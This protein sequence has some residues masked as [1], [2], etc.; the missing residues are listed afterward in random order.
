[1]NLQ[2]LVAYIKEQKIQGVPDI[3]I[4]QTLVNAG[5]SDVLI[6]QG[7]AAY[8]KSLQPKAAPLKKKRITLSRT[9][10]KVIVWVLGVVLLLVL[11]VVGV[12]LAHRNNIVDVSRLGLSATPQKNLALMLAQLERGLAQPAFDLKIRIEAS[13]WPI[14]PGYAH[15]VATPIN[16]LAADME[17]TVPGKNKSGGGFFTLLLVAEPGTRAETR[18]LESEMRY[19]AEH[20]T[21]YVRIGES[22]LLN[23]FGFDDFGRVWME[24]DN[25]A[26][27]RTGEQFFGDE[28]GVM[29]AVPTPEAV[30]VV[31]ST[32]L[33]ALQ[34]AAAELTASDQVVVLESQDRSGERSFRYEIPVGSSALSLVRDLLRDSGVG[35]FF[36]QAP[37]PS[38]PLALERIET[39]PIQV[40]FGEATKRLYR[41][42]I[43]LVYNH[44]DGSMSR[45]VIRVDIVRHG[46]PT[47]VARPSGERLDPAL[48]AEWLSARMVDPE[49]ASSTPSVD[50]PLMRSGQDYL[51]SMDLFL[52]LIDPLLQE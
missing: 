28:G 32:F 27:M 50:S 19:L 7:F 11:L 18:L 17:A 14:L 30:T 4:S 46:N 16:L 44:T 41:I 26:L 9:T 5:W 35:S 10:R 39:S 15:E 33:R 20:E 40:W 45:V 34:Q 43:P 42:Q 48:V 36:G 6:Q 21:T 51:L 8:A 52:N 49:T 37:N 38:V 47:P 22:A 24:F 31:G 3:Q 1:M 23:A 12:V 29:I 25:E 13:D 2:P